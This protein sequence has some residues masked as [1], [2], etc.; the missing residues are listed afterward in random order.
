MSV[1]SD[2][3][4]SLQKTLTTSFSCS[5]ISMLDTDTFVVSTLDH[6]RSVCTVDV[7]GNEGDIQQNILFDKQYG[8]WECACA[9]VPSTKTIVV[10]EKN[11]HT[12]YMCDI[13]SGK[14]HVINN[15]QIRG[16][17]GICPGPAGTVLVC[18]GDTDSLVHLSPQGD[19]LGSISVGMKFT[20]AVS[21]SKDATR[22]VLANACAKDRVIKLF[23]I[24]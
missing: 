7:H 9:F 3:T 21:I 16:P 12:I 20:K 1:S 19:V 17:R 23:S 5:S 8:L 18:S 6:R 13:T 22:L 14:F 2:S 10:S 11:Q 15:D 4:L 24:V